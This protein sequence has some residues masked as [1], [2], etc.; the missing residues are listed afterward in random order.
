MKFFTLSF[1][2]LV[3]FYS[4]VRAQQQN[5]NQQ[6]VATELSKQLNQLESARA[7]KLNQYLLTHP[8]ARR[9]YINAKGNYSY[10]HRI[11]QDGTP[12]YYQTRSNLALA[13]SI[14]TSKLWSGGSL[15]LNLQGQN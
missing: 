6:L 5:A 3:C 7:L 12:V 15:G 8:N 9:S 14:G 1:A 10:L 13:T 2:L 4:S 11:D